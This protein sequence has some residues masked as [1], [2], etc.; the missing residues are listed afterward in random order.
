MLKSI[1]TEIST[2]ITRIINQSLNTGTF[3]DNLKLA[4]VIPIHKK[5]DNKLFDNYRPISILPAISKVFE[6]VIFDQLYEH[7]NSN[8]L[9]YSSQYGFKKNHSTELAVLELIDR[10]TEEL[11]KGNI[12]INILYLDLSK[13]FDTLNHHILL[14]KLKYYGLNNS[15]IKICQSYLDNRKQYVEYNNAKSKLTD[16]NVGVPQG[17]IMGSLLFIIYTII[18][19]MD[20][21][22][23]RTSPH[24][25]SHLW[26]LFGVF[27]DRVLSRSL[28]ERSYNV[29]LDILYRLLGFGTLVRRLSLPK[30][31]KTQFYASSRLAVRRRHRSANEH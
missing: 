29:P 17:S 8:G 16:I 22:T 15:A 11:D 25:T 19:L 24:R 12:P 26:R 28:C 5:G 13:A 9:F 30:T 6:K 18:L 20:T 27:T 7:F 23:H 10:I 21:V 2:A 31:Q 4:K 14:H 3:P 1:K